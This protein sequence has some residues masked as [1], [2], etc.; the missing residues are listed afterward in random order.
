[1]HEQ[2]LSDLDPSD[3]SQNHSMKKHKGNEGWNKAEAVR[4]GPSA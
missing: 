1:M 4:K 2:V 3:L